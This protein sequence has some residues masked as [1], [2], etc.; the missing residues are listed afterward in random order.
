MRCSGPGVAA[1]F[2]MAVMECTA[3]ELQVVGDG[4]PEPLATGGD[5]A[6]GRALIVARE[7]AN[8]ALCHAIPDRAVPFSGNVGPSLS[9]IGTRMTAA[10]LRLRIA[11]NIRLNPATVMPSYYRT[12][13]FDRVASAYAGKPI[14]SAQEMED[15]VAYLGTLR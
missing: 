4:I 14:L 3:V 9:G 8:C 15:V 1:A 7:S 5:V 12:E 13:G 11:D 6:R 2:M 10:Q